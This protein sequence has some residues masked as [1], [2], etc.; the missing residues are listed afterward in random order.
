MRV[1]AVTCPDARQ[2]LLSHDDHGLLQATQQDVSLQFSAM[3]HVNDLRRPAGTANAIS[4]TASNELSAWSHPARLDRVCVCVCVLDLC[5][6]SCLVSFP[7]L[8]PSVVGR[9]DLRLSVCMSFRGLYRPL[10]GLDL[11]LCVCLFR[12]DRPLWG[13]AVHVLFV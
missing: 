6:C 8:V 2:V 11:R 7:G 13:F 9:L 3:T 10:G 4:A 1:P 12:G 5:L